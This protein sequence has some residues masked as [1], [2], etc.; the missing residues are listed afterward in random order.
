[1]S[2]QITPVIYSIVTINKESKEFNEGP[3]YIVTNRESN[4]YFRVSYSIVTNI[5][6]NFKSFNEFT[7]FT[8]KF[9]TNFP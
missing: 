3:Y 8:V 7:T 6:T 5:I 9:V 4:E 2:N 1:M